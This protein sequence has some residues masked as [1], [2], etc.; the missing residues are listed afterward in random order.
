M[1]KI[2][3]RYLEPS[4]RKGYPWPASALT[5]KEMA[6]LARWRQQTGVPICELLRQSVQIAQ[7]LFKKREINRRRD[8]RC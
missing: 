2:R 4:E 8:E 6:V 7:K 1:T 3:E 5:G